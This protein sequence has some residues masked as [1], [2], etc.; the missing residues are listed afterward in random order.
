MFQHKLGYLVARLVDDAVLV[1][2]FLFLTMDGTPEGDRLWKKLRLQKEDKTYLGIDTV[3]FFVMTD[4]QYD[5]EI[6]QMLSECG[7]GHLFKIFKE[8]P[9]VYHR[10]VAADLRKHLMLGDK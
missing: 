9:T 2:S 10:G 6:V 3:Q 5:H 8:P 4:I 1:E 7:C